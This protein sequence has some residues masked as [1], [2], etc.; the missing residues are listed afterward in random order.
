MANLQI[1]FSVRRQSETEKYFLHLKLVS[2]AGTPTKIKVQYTESFEIASIDSTYLN[3]RFNISLILLQ[4]TYL[5]FFMT[6]TNDP[7]LSIQSSSTW[8][9]NFCSLFKIQFE[10]ALNISWK[11]SVNSNVQR[12]SVSA[13]RYWWRILATKIRHIWWFIWYESYLQDFNKNAVDKI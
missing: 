13:A 9:K 11:K 6:S 12:Q 1:T 2:V 4:M 5:S 3:N 8:T 7:I 10:L